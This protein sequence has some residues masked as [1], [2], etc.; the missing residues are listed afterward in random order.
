MSENSLRRFFMAHNDFISSYDDMGG[1]FTGLL[2]HQHESTGRRILRINRE[3]GAAVFMPEAW[4]QEEVLRFHRHEDGSYK[5][6][7][8]VDGRVLDLDSRMSANGAKIH[9]WDD[10]GSD[11][12][13]WHIRKLGGWDYC[14]LGEAFSFGPKCAGNSAFDVG[15]GNACLWD[16]HGGWQQQFGIY[17][18]DLDAHCKNEKHNDTSANLSTANVQKVCQSLITTFKYE[19]LNCQSMFAYDLIKSGCVSRLGDYTV[20]IDKGNLAEMEAGVCLLALIKGHAAPH[21][22]V[23]LSQPEII[24]VFKYGFGE[25]MCD[26]NETNLFQKRCLRINNYRLKTSGAWVLE[27]DVHK[28]HSLF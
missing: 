19:M 13:R 17:R 5:I 26:I 25:I 10:H 15:D 8:E 11:N 12:Q 16:Y 4:I 27:I 23:K 14:G 3:S 18:V 2:V 7:S 24:E 6:K 28:E 20:T 9:F 1:D 22:N 21:S